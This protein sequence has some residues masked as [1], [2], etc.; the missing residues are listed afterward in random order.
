[1]PILQI[2]RNGQITLPAKFCGELGL[3]KGDIISAEIQAGR[4]ILTPVA[5][6]E[7]RKAKKRALAKEKFFEM[8]NEL[9]ERTKDV[10]FSE[11]QAAID[12]AAVAAKVVSASRRINQTSTGENNERRN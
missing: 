2:L 6:I 8:V 1:M 5:L 12:E 3:K 7:D 11:I 10:P 4:I 9:R